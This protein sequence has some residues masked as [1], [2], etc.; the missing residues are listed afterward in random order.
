MSIFD[1]PTPEEMARAKAAD[2]LLDELTRHII[3]RLP[4]GKEKYCGQAMMLAQECIGALQDIST[5]G[6]HSAMD[7]DTAKQTLVY[8]T[9]V[10]SG[11]DSFI[12]QHDLK[13]CVKDVD[14][15]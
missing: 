15:C 7:E 13:G 6:A 9:A 12:A 1:R 2:Q 10:K 4:D 14:D 5:A 11:L 3:E 8:L